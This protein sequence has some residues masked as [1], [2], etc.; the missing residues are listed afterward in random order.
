MLDEGKKGLQMATGKRIS[1]PKYTQHISEMMKPLLALE[2]Q[3][4][5]FDQGIRGRKKN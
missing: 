2:S 1:T 5:N 4:R 3:V